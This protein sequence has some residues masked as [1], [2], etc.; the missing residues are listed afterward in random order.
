MNSAYYCSYAA[1]GHSELSD[2]NLD[3]NNEGNEGDEGNE[4]S[5]EGDEGDEVGAPGGALIHLPL[6]ILLYWC[7]ELESS[8][9]E[10]LFDERTVLLAIGKLS[11]HTYPH[12]LCFLVVV[13]GSLGYT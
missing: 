5:D 6:I 1:A 3:D 10:H 13:E 11:T 4:G 7:S 9:R 2:A 8:A 12:W